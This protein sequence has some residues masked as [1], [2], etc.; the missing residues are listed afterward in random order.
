MVQK[1]ALRERL[2]EEDPTGPRSLS[3]PLSRRHSDGGRL[4]QLNWPRFEDVDHVVTRPPT[5]FFLPH[6]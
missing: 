6:L 5:A 3:P 4:L 2:G 1:A